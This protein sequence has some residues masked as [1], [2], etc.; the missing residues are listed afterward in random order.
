MRGDQVEKRHNMEI[1]YSALRR[2]DLYQDENLFL[3]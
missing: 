2:T 1:A 3:N